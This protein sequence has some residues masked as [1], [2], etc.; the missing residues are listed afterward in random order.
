MLNAKPRGDLSCT[1][2]CCQGTAFLPHFEYMPSPFIH[3]ERPR[4]DKGQQMMVEYFRQE[5]PQQRWVI[6]SLYSFMMFTKISVYVCAFLGCSRYNWRI[7]TKSTK[8]PDWGHFLCNPNICL[9][10]YF[11]NNLTMINRAQL[12]EICNITQT[13]FLSLCLRV[14]IE[15]QTFVL[16]EEYKSFP[17]L[18]ISGT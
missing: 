5:K 13:S 12:R 10:D 14:Q 15:S 11:L 7:N 1:E 3:Y 6:C 2:M 4:N 16:F 9:Q 8:Y 18:A 17:L